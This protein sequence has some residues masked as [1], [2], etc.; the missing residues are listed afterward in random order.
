MSFACAYLRCVVWFG[1]I[2]SAGDWN[3]ECMPAVQPVPDLL[4]KIGESSIGD[5]G[6]AP[7]KV[8][9]DLNAFARD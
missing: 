8:L 6:D 5:V 9:L 7:A 3:G 4:D 1:Q 2:P